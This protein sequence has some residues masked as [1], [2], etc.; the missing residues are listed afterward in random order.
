M[1]Y[2]YWNRLYTLCYLAHGELAWLFLEP[3]TGLNHCPRIRLTCFEARSSGFH[4][5]MGYPLSSISAVSISSPPSIDY[6]HIRPSRTHCEHFLPCC[7][8]RLPV[9]GYGFRQFNTRSI[10]GTVKTF[11]TQY[12]ASISGLRSGKITQNRESD[13]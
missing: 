10:F 3:D 5:C 4:P 2:P 11:Y 13:D 9:P 8:P 1:V 7:A 12:N 6:G